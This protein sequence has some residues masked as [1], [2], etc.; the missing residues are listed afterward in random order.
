MIGYIQYTRHIAYPPEYLR[1]ER[2]QAYS[3]IM[4]NIIKVNR[5]AMELSEED[6]FQVELE[7]Y[8]MAKESEFTEPVQDVTE[9][10]HRNYHVIDPGVKNTVNDYLDFIS[11]YPEGQV[12]AGEL[13]S[14]ASVII[15]EMRADLQLTSV[16]PDTMDQRKSSKDT[17]E[18]E[19]GTV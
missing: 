7:R 16:F 18:R 10:L 1:R 14:L 15:A 17:S 11:Q 8:T 4:H 5:L 9:A 3:E 6:K 19:N 12:H 2:L 13:L